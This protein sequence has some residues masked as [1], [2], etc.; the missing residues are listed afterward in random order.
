M[1]V[2]HHNHSPLLKQFIKFASIGLIGTLAQYFVLW[3]GIE[4]FYQA[5]SLSSGVGYLLGSMINYYLNYHFT[6]NSTKTHIEAASKF[7]LIVI[8]GWSINTGIMWILA[9]QLLWNYWL[10]QL[11]ATAT[12]LLWNFF[13]SRLWAFHVSETEP[14]KKM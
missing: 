6:F 10:S 4:F 2:R 11:L 9:D 3:I 12:G 7:Y 5:A 1:T 14:C 8:I 13:G